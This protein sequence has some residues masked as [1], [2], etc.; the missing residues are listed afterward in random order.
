MLGILPDENDCSFAQKNSSTSGTGCN[1]EQPVST[2]I[3]LQQE[4][5]ASCRNCSAELLQGRQRPSPWRTE[6]ALQRTLWATLVHN[7]R[8]EILAQRKVTCPRQCCCEGMPGD[9]SQ[10]KQREEF[11]FLEHS[12]CQAQ[13]PAT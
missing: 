4:P 1:Q 5:Q 8:E 13:V 2:F 3:Q 12:N 10:T 11:E 6:C 7:A 9:T